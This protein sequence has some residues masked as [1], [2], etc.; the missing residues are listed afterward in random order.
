MRTGKQRN[1]IDRKYY[2]GHS[3]RKF[4]VVQINILIMIIPYI[5]QTRYTFKRIN[6]LMQ[7]IAKN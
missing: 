6:A 4:M 5:L 7:V 2:D 3:E 1:I